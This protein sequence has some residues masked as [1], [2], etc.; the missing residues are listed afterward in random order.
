MIIYIYTR[1]IDM[2]VSWRFKHPRL[3]TPMI[4]AVG[5]GWLNPLF[6]QLLAWFSPNL[7]VSQTLE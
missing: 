5:G 1:L 2:D 3:V 7:S 6:S 4:A